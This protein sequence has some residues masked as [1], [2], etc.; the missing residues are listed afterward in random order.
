MELNFSI[1]WIYL[2][3]GQICTKGKFCTRL[4]NKITIRQFCTKGQICTK[5]KKK[6]KKK[7]YKEKKNIN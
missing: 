1:V 7:K 5:V 6:Q 2:G 4:Q 3:A